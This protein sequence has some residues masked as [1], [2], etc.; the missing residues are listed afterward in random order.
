MTKGILRAAL[1]AGLLAAPATNAMAADTTVIRD[2][3]GQDVARMVEGAG[4]RAELGEDGVG[5]P[6]ITSSAAGANYYIYMYG[7]EDGRCDSLQFRAGFDLDDGISAARVN[8]WNRERRYGKAWMD[9]ENDPWIELDLD[10]EGGATGAQV[11][12]Y[13]ELW[14]TLL[15]QFQTFIY[16]E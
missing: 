4:Y 15:G 8:E 10:L 1:L 7:C 12:S 6:M 13:V 5:D 3:S 11:V 16:A 9:E 2:I 14:D